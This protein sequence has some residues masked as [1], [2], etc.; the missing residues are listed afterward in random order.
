[1]RKGFRLER[2]AMM[3]TVRELRHTKSV[4]LARAFLRRHRTTVVF[5]TFSTG[6]TRSDHGVGEHTVA[7]RCDI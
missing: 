2:P 3:A 7:R 5:R 4:A 1:M 6:L